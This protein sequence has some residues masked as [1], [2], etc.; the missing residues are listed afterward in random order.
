MVRGDCSVGVR[1]DCNIGVRGGCSAC[2]P[3]QAGGV[4]ECAAAG[5]SISQVC[6]DLCVVRATCG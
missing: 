4:G 5:S 6:D 3:H 2:A 1:I